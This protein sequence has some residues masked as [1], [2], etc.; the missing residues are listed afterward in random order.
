MRHRRLS[1][2][3]LT[4]SLAFALAAAAQPVERQDLGERVPTKDELVSML[5]VKPALPTRSGEPAPPPVPRAISSAIG[6]EL[7]SAVLNARGKE[8][9]N[10]LGAA[11][12][13]QAFAN[14]RI[15]LEGHADATGSESH[16]LDLSQRRANAVRQFLVDVWSLPAANVTAVGKGEG[17][18]L[19]KSNPESGSNRAVVIVNTGSRAD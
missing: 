11:L 8:F 4:T 10:N 12:S 18:L 3:L 7:N 1:A 14:A 17:D 2:L 19:D 6:F 16:N 15:L 9:L 13:D 5:V